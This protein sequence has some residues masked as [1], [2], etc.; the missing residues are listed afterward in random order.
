M[1]TARNKKLTLDRYKCPVCGE[2][3]TKQTGYFFKTKDAN[4]I[5]N[6]G[7]ITICKSCLQKMFEQYI[8]FYDSIP[9]AIRHICIMF[10]YY[11][12]ENGVRDLEA[13]LAPKIGDY[14][15]SINN[16]KKTYL[17]TILEEHDKKT[18]QGA[19]N[20]LKEEEADK[21]K[22]DQEIDDEVKFFFGD[23]FTYNDY[24][25]LVA[26]FN[27]WKKRI[28]ENLTKSEEGLLRNIVFNELDMMKA[29]QN[30]ES[31]KDLEAT[32]LNN[33]K[34][35]GWSPNQNTEDTT[36]LDCFGQWI[37]RI[38]DNDPIP[39]PDPEWEDVDGIKD[40]IEAFQLVP[41]AKSIG[42]KGFDDSKAYDRLMDKFS[43]KKKQVKLND[44]EDELFDKALG[45]VNEE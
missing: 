41:L 16:I 44:E 32:Y 37:N 20:A 36:G 19:I 38:E 43:V 7:Y 12:S 45:V 11:Y 42:L 25:F 8:K 39:D 34:A 23:G 28:G 30:G 4:Y 2:S 17:D 13:S 14:I 40:Y 27:E 1:A 10:G 21:I 18:Q 15:K 29:R 5:K 3:F 6:N 22:V 26:D 35:G 24:E 31:T 9:K 33:L